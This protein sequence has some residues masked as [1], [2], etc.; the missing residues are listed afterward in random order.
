ML[1]LARVPMLAGVHRE[2]CPKLIPG[3]GKKYAKYPQ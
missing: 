1:P 2:Y 3:C